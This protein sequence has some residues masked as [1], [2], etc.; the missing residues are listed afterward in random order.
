MVSRRCRQNNN[1]ARQILSAATGN[2]LVFMIVG[3][4]VISVIAWSAY[5]LYA[6]HNDPANPNI[7]ITSPE[8]IPAATP[9]ITEEQPAEAIL[10]PVPGPLQAEEE[11]SGSA[12][13]AEPAIVT[14]DSAAPC[15]P[16]QYSCFR[17]DSDTKLDPQ[18][19]SYKSVWAYYSSDKGIHW[20]R[21]GC[22]ATEID[23]AKGIIAANSQAERTRKLVENATAKRAADQANTNAAPVAVTAPI[24]ESHTP[25]A[26]IPSANETAGFEAKFK[27]AFG[28]TV[29]KRTYRT[30]EMKHKALNLW[31]KERKLLEP[32]GTINEKYTIQPQSSGMIPGH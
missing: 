19:P 12:T 28:L 10:E 30:A 6:H 2:S 25:P 32:D 5:Y 18:C 1:P 29:E 26:P 21:A 31:D 4:L 9:P 14:I 3:I 7:I 20:K 23:A 8:N 24:P 16:G 15:P 22:Y 13:E 11:S 27:G 17:T